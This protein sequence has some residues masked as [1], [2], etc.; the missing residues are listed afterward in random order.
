M[1]TT[2]PHCGCSL[3]FVV[4]AFCPQCRED[5]R[6]VPKQ[7]LATAC[8]AEPA[9]GWGRRNL[10]PRLRRAASPTV[11]RPGSPLAKLAGLGALLGLISASFDLKRSE[12]LQ[13]IAKERP[14]YAG[15][16]VTGQVLF[17]A[18]VA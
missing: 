8:T 13:Q 14:G 5:L 3:P 16:Y 4:D 9:D 18:L 10:P 11:D 15:G 6:E 2:C 1:R 7:S 12:R 17:G